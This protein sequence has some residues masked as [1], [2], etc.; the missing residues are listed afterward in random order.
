MQHILLIYSVETKMK[1]LN[2]AERGQMHAAY[3][4]YTQ[5]LIKAGVMKA[6]D[7]LQKSSAATTVRIEGGKTKV[8]DG[9]YAETKEQ[10][11]GYYIVDVPDADAALSWAAKCPGA[12]YGTMEVRPIVM[13]G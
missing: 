5:A 1:A 2:D 4:A 12:S 10:L 13:M 3:G 6:G 11:A 8:L 9:P 7:Q